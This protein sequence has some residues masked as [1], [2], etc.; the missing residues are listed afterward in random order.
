MTCTVRLFLT[1]LDKRQTLLKSLATLK[2]D[3]SRLR[4]LISSKTGQVHDMSKQLE[5]VS[6]AEVDLRSLIQDL[7]SKLEH[8]KSTYSR[9]QSALTVQ[10]DHLSKASEQ[11]CSVQT[12]LQ[13]CSEEKKG[14]LA[15]LQSLREEKVVLSTKLNEMCSATA[16]PSDQIGK[17][18]DGWYSHL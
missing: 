6:L 15:S 12:L 2:T 18:L 9:V 7:F 1:H 5:S 8:M 16:K 17:F 13:Q 14:M 4:E 3:N 10:L 11:T